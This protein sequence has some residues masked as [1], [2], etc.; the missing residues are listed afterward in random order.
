MGDILIMSS[1][2]RLV[3]TGSKGLIGTKLVQHFKG[4][5]EILSLDLELGHDLSDEVFVNKWFSK[6]KNLYGIIVCHAYNPLP[7]ENTK[8]V[9]PIDVPLSE[10]RDYMEINVVSAFNVCKQFIKNNKGGRIINISSLY[11]L[12][13][14]K[15]FIYNDFTKHIGYSLSKSSVVLMSKYLSTYY[16]NNFNINTVIF[17]GVYDKRFDKEFVNNYNRNV[18]MNRMMDISEITSVFDFLLDEKSSYVNGTEIKVD[19]GWTAW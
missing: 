9:E 16:A 8:K 10:I 4:E 17:G 15:H 11:S 18:P 19:G 12:V 2:K 6:N 14:P 7:I 3:I 5:Y 1:K 13:S